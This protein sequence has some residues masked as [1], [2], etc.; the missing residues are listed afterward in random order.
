MDDRYEKSGCL[1]LSTEIT[2]RGSIS[3]KFKRLELRKQGLLDC[4]LKGRKVYI[5]VMAVM[6]R[7]GPV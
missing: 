1:F 3:R 4:R 7:K 5:E 6:E 2:V